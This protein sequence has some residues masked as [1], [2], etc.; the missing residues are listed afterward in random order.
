MPEQ[1]KKVISKYQGEKDYDKELAK[2]CRKITDVVPHKLK[3]VTSND[4]EYWG[5]K[6][7]LTPPMVKVLNKMKLRKF[8]LFEELLKMNPEYNPVDFQ[9]LLDDMAV[10]GILEYDY[11]DNYNDDGPIP[12]AP[13]IKRY[14]LSYFVPGSAELMNS[15]VERIAKNPAVASFFERMTFIPLAGITEML[16]PG[17]GGVGMHVIPVE[18]AIANE[19]ESLD[20]EHISHWMKKYEGH[21][22]AGICSCRA[23]RA[24]LGEG[25]IDDNDDWCIQFGDMAD[26]TVETGRAHYITKERALEIFELSEKNGFVHQITNIDGENKIFDIC[27]CDVKICNALRTALLF[28][29][30][31]LERSA[32]TARVTKDNCV[33]CGRCVENCPAGA[34]KLGQKLCKGDGKEQT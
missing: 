22:S 10:V 29:T 26:Y 27:N 23:S 15:T 2:L 18:K 19:K 31:N 4:P 13:K 17:G 34:V 24:M 32:Y 30:P 9:K 14:M 28:N 11:G 6:E 21:I 7:V 8:Y 3:G 20:I 16:P 12:N 5:L 1:S 33:A 25:C